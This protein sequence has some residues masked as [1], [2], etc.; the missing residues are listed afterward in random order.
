MH[1]S[2]LVQT[3]RLAHVSQHRKDYHAQCARA[4]RQKYTQR[5]SKDRKRMRLQVLK[6][7][8]C[9]ARPAPAQNR[10]PFTA[11]SCDNDSRKAF[12]IEN[13]KNPHFCVRERTQARERASESG[14]QRETEM[15]KRRKEQKYQ[16]YGHRSSSINQ[17]THTRSYNGL[18]SSS[19]LTSIHKK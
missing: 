2:I 16:A 6:S 17:F 15:K 13:T 3:L 9:F 10:S 19:H 8:M 4:T 7:G 11:R 14:K 1:T 12:L 18:L 5:R